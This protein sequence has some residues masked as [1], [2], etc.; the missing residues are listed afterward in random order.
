MN[1]VHKSILLIVIVLLISVVGVVFAE[2]SSVNDDTAVTAPDV[3]ISDISEGSNHVVERIDNCVDEK[4]FESV[5]QLGTCQHNIS[6]CDELNTSCHNAAENYSCYT[7][8]INI[9]KTAK[10]CNT[11]GY[12]ISKYNFSTEEY[13]CSIDTTDKDSTVMV[14][15]S[16][17]DGNGDG[18]CT[19]GESCMKYV[20]TKD[21]IASF[22]K[23]S[24][25]EY[26]PA[27]ESYF[28]NK[29]TVEEA[30]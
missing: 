15:D 26:A 4:Y 18:I 22:E 8:S 16:K 29:I 9:E 20:I 23:N 19:S 11:K 1:S 6:V 3:N 17:Y 2:I 30:Q 21:S 25:D 13:S 12:K 28:L 5:P 24:K 14:C 27:D 7:N 10:K